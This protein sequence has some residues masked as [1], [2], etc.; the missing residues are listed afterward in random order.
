ML[1]CRDFWIFGYL[2]D[3]P[4]LSSPFSSLFHLLPSILF[5]GAQDAQ[6]DLPMMP[7]RLIVLM[8]KPASFSEVSPGTAS[9]RVYTWGCFFVGVTEISFKHYSTVWNPRTCKLVNLRPNRLSVSIQKCPNCSRAHNYNGKGFRLLPIFLSSL[10]SITQGTQGGFQG[11]NQAIISRKTWPRS[12]VLETPKLD[13]SPKPRPKPRT[14]N[15]KPQTQTA[16]PKA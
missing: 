11:K 16:N 4:S 9:V 14:L 12:F 15:P 3:P 8:Q 10:T 7:M 1:Q 6:E 2:G 5:H 13:P